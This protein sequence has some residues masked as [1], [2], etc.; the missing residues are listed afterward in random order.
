VRTDAELLRSDLD[1]RR[2]ALDVRRSFIVQAPA[3]SGKTELLIQRYL[4]LLATVD[5]PEEILAITFTRKAAAE[6][7]YRVVTAL[8]RAASGVPPAKA[9]ERVT[10]DAACAVLERDRDR[11]WNLVASARRMRIQTLDSFCAGVARLLPVTSGMGVGGAVI[12]DLRAEFVYRRAALATLDWLAGDDDLSASVENVLTHLD[13]NTNL[14]ID[15]IAR[16]LQSRDQ[17]LEITGSGTSVDAEA[18][19]RRL[20]SNIGDIVRHQL[21]VTRERLAAAAPDNLMPLCHYAADNL[22][23]AG[24]TEHGAAKLRDLEHLPPAEADCL[25]AWQ[26][27]AEL[28]LTGKGEWRRQVTRG[29]GFP[30]GDAGQKDDW[31]TVIRELSRHRGINDDLAA[32][33]RLPSPEYSDQQWNV[34]LAL[35]RVLPLAVSELKRIFA[36]EGVCDYVEVSLAAGAALGSAE[37]PGD[38]AMMLDYRISHLLVDEMQD[39]SISQ[40]RMLE[41]LT[42]G[43]QP[44]D[45]RTFFCVGDPMQSIYRFRN[46]EVGQF[47]RAREQGL[48]S[49]RLESLT[50]R[51]NFRSGERLVHW[52]N[53]VFSDL[54]PDTD[55]PSTGAVRYSNSVAVEGQSGQGEQR[56]HP[57]F[58]ADAEAEADYVADVVEN[59]LAESPSGTVAVLVRSRTQLPELLAVLRR[60][61]ITYR[62]VEIDRLTDL[63]EIIDLLALTRA[64]CHPADRAA[65][66]ALL[67]GPLAGLDWT[68][69]HRLVH[70]ATHETVWQLLQDPG[71]MSA[72][73]TAGQRL[74]G[75]FVD[76]LRVG[77]RRDGLLSLRDRVEQTW[78]RLGGPACLGSAEQ[79]ANACRF[80]DVVEKIET[81]GTI[82]DPATIQQV[83]ESERVSS[84]VRDD[85]RVEIMTMHKAK[86]LQFEHV[87]LPSLGRYTSASRRSVLSWLNVPADRGGSD[88]ILSPVG[89]SYELERDPLHRYIEQARSHSESLEQDRLLYVACTRAVATLD[90]IGRVSLS[91]DGEGIRP[92]D[93]RTLLSRLWAAVGDTARREFGDRRPAHSPDADDVDEAVYVLPELR[94]KAAEFRMP[95]PPPLPASRRR[96]AA[97]SD[98]ELA[99]VHYD[100]VGASARD[101]GTI[102]HR[103]LMR[104]AAGGSVPAD[105]G[106]LA[107]ADALTDAWARSL[108]VTPQNMPVVRR[109]VHD[110]LRGILSDARGRWLLEGEGY[111]ELPLTGVW[112]GRIV[113]VVIDR[114]RIDAD[115]HWI[116][117]YKT[118]SHEGG[119][120]SGFLD[121]EADR[122]APQLSRYKAIYESYS[123]A[124]QV[125]AAL[126]FP[127]IRSFREVEV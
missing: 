76:I 47:V 35:F 64:I 22:I 9:H 25:A 46:A 7:R 82:P 98:E 52:F 105:P 93:K 30:P 32:I 24:Q 127:L 54:L 78:F 49:L 26:G 53:A 12:Q 110:S 14:Y 63:P 42:A 97:S 41:T 17:W 3:G 51:R 44:G 117:D 16:M 40:Y 90:L 18:I 81:A 19:R 68:D 39:T 23:A 29:Q 59:R 62:A 88:L 95:E 114:V 91:A 36:E 38:L 86:G 73:S 10:F 104:I 34:L 126:Y 13:G 28:L 61:D 55:D 8:Q 100:W 5:D 113:S 83:L 74:S 115:T 107:G 103:W 121:Q 106:D 99:E 77:L 31:M 70:G 79:A 116:V 67:R 122:Y 112:Q 43:W 69:L 111:A 108:G 2:V 120:L 57:L 84:T 11:E 65:W 125:R 71:R 85:C 123:G 80:L 27:L 96:I 102:V 15:Y 37:A 50:L 56:F 89:P 1:A 33:V 4:R 45:G 119:D 20:E 60:R 66:L 75:D 92:P 48:G 87:I 118:S 101:A 21:A 124:G 109:R 58:D 72:M 94:R 6:M